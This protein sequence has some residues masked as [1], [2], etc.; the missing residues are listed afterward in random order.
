MIDSS[1]IIVGCPRSGTSLLYNILSEIPSLWALGYESKAI[2]ERYHH[3]SV[4]NWSSGE[5]TGSDLSQESRS[6]M[7]DTFFKYSAPGS[8]WQKVNWL[9]NQVRNNPI[10]QSVKRSGGSNSRSGTIS[11][12]IPHLGLDVLRLLIPFRN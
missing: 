6:W 3:P 12:S 4:A 8:F 7:L 1:L 5:L 11:T 2:I 9:R 10:W